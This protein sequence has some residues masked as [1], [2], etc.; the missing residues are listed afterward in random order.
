MSMKINKIIIMRK[1]HL[2]PKW[3]G[4]AGMTQIRFFFVD[5]FKNLCR[6]AR[7]K[8]FSIADLRFKIATDPF[9]TS[10]KFSTDRLRTG[11]ECRM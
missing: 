7:G 4:F 3:Q 11:V 5:I 8:G 9:D 1:A 6:I 2:C 10:T